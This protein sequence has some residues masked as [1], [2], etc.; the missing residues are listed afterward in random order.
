M[1]RTAMCRFS[2]TDKTLRSQRTLVT[3]QQ[4]LPL[5]AIQPYQKL[6]KGEYRIPFKIQLPSSIPASQEEYPIKRQ[7]Q[8]QQ[9]KRLPRNGFVVEYELQAALG[10]LQIATNLIV[11]ASPLPTDQ[12]LPYFVQPI[13]IP[14]S[15]F[16]VIQ[17]GELVVGARVEETAVGRGQTIRLRLACRNESTIE[18]RRVAIKLQETVEWHVEG[19]G[20]TQRGAQTLV[21]LQDVNLPSLSRDAKER[22]EVRRLRRDASSREFTHSTIY[23]DLVSENMQ[24]ILIVV[25]ETARDS[26]DGQLIKVRH[27]LSVKLKTRNLS[28]NAS[29]SIPIRIGT[30][31]SCNTPTTSVVPNS[32][33]VT[34]PTGRE[35]LVAQAVAVNDTTNE[36]QNTDDD[37][38]SVIVLSG[39]AVLPIH[40]SLE[41]VEPLPAPLPNEIS[42][43]NLLHRID[44]SLNTP[45]MIASLLMET[46]WVRFFSTMTQ[47]DFASI[48][49]N[50]SPEDDQ[51]RVA[52]LLS[53]YVNGGDALTCSW[54]AACVRATAKDFRVTTARRLLGHCNDLT[55][56]YEILR[57][58]L[59]PW[60]RMVFE[61]DLK[62]V[63]LSR[64]N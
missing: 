43:P 47:A 3:I 6:R 38:Q 1:E 12:S 52:V 13:S 41:D 45:A 15:S 29:I 58:E 5:K 21:H 4:T 23:N 16:N 17:S 36:N 22:S 28:S 60:D 24:D 35:I 59:D 34:H 55:R 62:K 20:K 27:V 46:G 25:P 53:E 57:N 40:S 31:K 42:L 18:I 14:I 11:Q 32:P 26:Y 56:N 37:V 19:I 39:D 49:R 7:Q 54:A 33:L 61:G 8:T 10:N 48:I 30:P 51:P 2:K 9:V 44:V 63:L 50:I 64:P